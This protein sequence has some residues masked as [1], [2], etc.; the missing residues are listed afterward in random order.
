MV[1]RGPGERAAPAAPPPGGAETPPPLAL[2]VYSRFSDPPAQRRPSPKNTGPISRLPCRK[3]VNAVGRS[4][5]AVN[6][7][8]S[9]ER[10]GTPTAESCAP[11]VEPEFSQPCPLAPLFAHGQAAPVPSPKQKALIPVSHSSGI[12]FPFESWLGPPAMS[13]AP[14]VVVP[15]TSGSP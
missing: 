14:G 5:V 1:P 4:P 7:S 11:P 3:I 12:P 8:V 6:T 9:A 10:L 13:P 15:F 2:F